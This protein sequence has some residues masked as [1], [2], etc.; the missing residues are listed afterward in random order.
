M[1]RVRIDSIAAGG[2][3][4][5]RAEG[6]V[7]F[8]PRAAP[9][10][11]LEVRLAGKK[12]FARGSITRVEQ[13]SPDR[14]DPPCGHYVRDRCGGCQVQHLAYP[15]Q[16][17]AKAG[18]IRDG[19]TRIGKRETTLPD[20]QR[21]PV[22]WRYRAK[23]TLAIRGRGDARVIGLHPYDDPDAVFQLADCPITDERVVALW[24]EIMK[25]AELLPERASRGSVRILDDHAAS[26]V[27]EG[28]S[29][30]DAADR[31]LDAIPAIASLW[32][33]PENQARRLVASRARDLSGASFA[34]VNPAMAAVL[35]QH[36]LD[37]V[38]RHAPRSMVDGY[39]GSGATAIPLANE[40]IA[41]TAIELDAHAAAA[42]SA[43][44]P[45]TS[46]SL[47]GRVED[48]LPSA[49]PADLVLLNPPRTGLADAVPVQLEGANPR[50]RAVIYVSC[51]PAT[52]GRDLARMPGYRIES[53][54][55]FDM[56]PQTAHVETVCELVP[57]AA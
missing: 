17:S 8:V 40:G 34:Q 38:R 27:I 13:A 55:G 28:D 25:R 18:I 24:R 50:P 30:W 41:V 19:L 54:R 23:L 6:M 35:R 48:L 10:D 32:W 1:A 26:V 44:L 15:A 47:S 5:G 14:V 57:E 39:S 20:V 33:K 31:L 51:N 42:C 52:L 29:R 3:G 36:V 43:R 9:G 12:R 21:S 56:F 53:V 4:V 11:V 22:E 37:R 46:R 16:L 49:L 45:A 2:D 7:V